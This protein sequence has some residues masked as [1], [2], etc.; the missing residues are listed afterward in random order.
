M[1][2][3]KSLMKSAGTVVAVVITVTAAQAAFNAYQS[4][5]AGDRIE[6][7]LTTL[8]PGLQITSI[9]CT[10]DTSFRERFFYFS[11]I[12]FCKNGP[13]MAPHATVL[14]PE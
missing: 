5:K 11:R 1:F 9:D 10:I 13:P 7:K 6:E 8:L 4:Q 14:C 2:N 3:K 12:T